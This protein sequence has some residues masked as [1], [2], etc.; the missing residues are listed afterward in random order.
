MKMLL[1]KMYFIIGLN[2]CN[3]EDGTLSSSC[4]KKEKFTTLSGQKF[5]PVVEGDYGS[6]GKRE[7]SLKPSAT[8]AFVAVSRHIHNNHPYLL[9]FS[10]FFEGMR[11]TTT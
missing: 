11:L 10:T 2:V 1:K 8:S 3:F 4:L 5:W 7:V 6:E 9:P